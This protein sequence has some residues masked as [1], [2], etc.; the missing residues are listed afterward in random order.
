MLNQISPVIIKNGI[1]YH[2]EEIVEFANPPVYEV[3]RVIEGI[4]L[5]FKEH[6]ER[7]FK[8]LS[9]IQAQTNLSKEDLLTG[10]ESLVT[11]TAILNNNVRL[12][13]GIDQQGASTWV[14]FWVKSQYPV[15]AVYELGVK[16]ITSRVTREN[17]HAKIYRK[18]YVETIN[19]LKQQTGAYE[20]ILIK[21]D[22]TVTEGSRSNLFFILDGKLYS[23]TEVDVLMGITRQKLIA[24]LNHMSIE[25]LEMDI[26]LNT[27]NKFEAC[28]ITGTSIHLLPVMAIDD[29][30]FNSANHPMFI[31]LETAFE[32]IV[33]DDLEHTRRLY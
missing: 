28:F 4:P 31:K 18:Q 12:E 6:V 11:E 24:M 25:L 17:P 19:A 29:L 2:S 14:L 21:D 9:L 8:S 15:K 30:L 16:T 20:V 3:I 7:L 5:Y 32:K 26:P 22:G 10:I 33:K 27:I 13:I 23:A 1:C